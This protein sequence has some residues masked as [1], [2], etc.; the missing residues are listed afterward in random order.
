MGPNR[1]HYR[2]L[3]FCQTTETSNLTRK[4][5]KTEVTRKCDSYFIT[6]CNKGLGF[7]CPIKSDNFI[8]NATVITKCVNFMTK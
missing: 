1:G 7:R 4:C 3:T 5:V 8:K 2:K 6:K